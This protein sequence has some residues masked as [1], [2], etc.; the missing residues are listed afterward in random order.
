MAE[1]DHHCVFC[2]IIA[3]EIAAL[4]VAETPHGLAFLD[5]GPLAE[6]HTLV[7]PKDHYRRLQEVPDEVLSAVVGLLPRVA[8]AVLQVTQAPAY[9]ILQNNGAQAGQVVEHVHFH[10]IPRRADDGL[11][12][13]WPAEPY[14]PGRGEWVQQQLLRSLSMID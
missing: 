1:R 5:R 7:I 10:I 11:G 12:F 9:N 2:K 6:G 3:G 14:P 8:R 4:K 13:R